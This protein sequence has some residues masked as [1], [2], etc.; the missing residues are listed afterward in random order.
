VLGMFGHLKSKKGA[1]F[2]VE[3]LLRSG[4]APRFHLLLVGEL[5]EALSALLQAHPE[6]P[7]TVVAAVDRFQLL[8]YYLASDLVVLPSHYDGFPN[9]LIEAA[10]LARPLLASSTGGMR[11]MLTDGE[12]AFLFAP[13]DDQGCVDAIARAADASDADLRRMGMSAA[14]NARRRCDARDETRG[15]LELFREAEE[16]LDAH[17]GSFAGVRAAAHRL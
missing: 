5:E 8:P 16:G 12:D 4:L 15:Y 2:F 14:S 11:D 6:V 7:A 9:V 13:G 3:A 10:A 17:P 1:T